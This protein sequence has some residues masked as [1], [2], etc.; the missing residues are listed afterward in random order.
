VIPAAHRC[1]ETEVS[2]YAVDEGSL[3]LPLSTP[4]PLGFFYTAR[5]GGA[6]PRFPAE[7]LPKI[8]I[9]SVSP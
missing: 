8:L 6:H 3:A 5:A 9:N 7:L 4:D 2:L 1:R